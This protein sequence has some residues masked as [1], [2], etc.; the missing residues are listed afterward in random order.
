MIRDYLRLIRVKHWVKSNAI[1]MY[2]KQPTLLRIET[3]IN[4]PY[5][6]KVRRPGQRKG[7]C[8]VDWFMMSKNVRNLPRYVEVSLQA[9]S[10]YLQGLSVV[11]D[12]S[13]HIRTLDT[14]CEPVVRSAR[15]TPITRWSRFG[16]NRSTLKRR[17]NRP[18]LRMRTK[19]NWLTSKK[20]PSNAGRLSTTTV[21]SNLFHELVQ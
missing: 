11:E 6:F 2:N 17:N 16:M 8:V 5:E 20:G 12:L 7:R 4:R 21:K 18:S 13:A 19:A 1:R 10:R 14:I 3:V 9:N 15:R